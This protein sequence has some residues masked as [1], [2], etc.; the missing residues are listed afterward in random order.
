MRVK[1][2]AGNGKNPDI[3]KAADEPQRLEIGNIMFFQEV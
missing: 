1:V 2:I 3:S